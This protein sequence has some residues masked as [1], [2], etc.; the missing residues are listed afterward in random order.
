MMLENA[1]LEADLRASVAEL[2]ASRARLASAADAGRREIERN[3]HDGAQQRLVALRMRLAEARLRRHRPSL[4][5]SLG[6]ARRRTEGTS[7]SCAAS[8]AAYTRRARRT[9]SA[10]ARRGG[11]SLPVPTTVIVDGGRRY[12]PEIEAAVY[13]CCREALQ[14]AAKHAG[15]G[16]RDR[17]RPG[18]RRTRRFEIRD[19]GVGFDLDASVAA[20]A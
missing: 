5:R 8:R 11:R 1:R 15:A 9:A 16:R 20:T 19:D 10:R 12:R 17:P 7:T 13:F 14:N 2:Q 18:E 6:R 3:L 4:P